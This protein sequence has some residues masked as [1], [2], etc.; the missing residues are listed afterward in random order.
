MWDVFARMHKT[1]FPRIYF[2]DT[3]PFVA[4][5][6]GFNGVSFLTT[7]PVWLH[8]SSFSYNLSALKQI[9]IGIR[10]KSWGFD[11]GGAF[12]IWRNEDADVHNLEA[13]YSDETGIVVRHLEV[14]FK[15]RGACRRK[16]QEHVW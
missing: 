14:V 4:G 9:S 15:E 5:Q 7:V 16:G 3:L 13:V 11:L 1:L 8:K 6:D 12:Y 10:S 2:Q